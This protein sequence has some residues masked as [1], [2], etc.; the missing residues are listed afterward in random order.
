[1]YVK[2]KHLIVVWVSTPKLSTLLEV[3]L[4][5]IP[6]G[7][8]SIGRTFIIVMRK[9]TSW[10]MYLLVLEISQIT[11][12]YTS[13]MCNHLAFA[14]ML[15]LYPHKTSLGLNYI[16]KTYNFVVYTSV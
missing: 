8:H 14:N 7:V 5:L 6:I 2:L 15:N 3:T 1:M 4:M 16:T 10:K 9:S 13:N 12:I 11:S